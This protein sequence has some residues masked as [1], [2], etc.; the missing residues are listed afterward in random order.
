MSDSLRSLISSKGSEQFTQKFLA[1]KSKFCFNMFYLRFLKKKILK[2]EWITHFCSFPLFCWAMLVNCTFCSI[3]MSNVS[4][5]LIL[6]TKNERMS[7]SLIFLSESLICSFFDKKLAIRSET[8]W[9]KS[10]P[11]FC[12]IDPSYWTGV[13][14][15]ETWQWSSSFAIP[16]EY[17]TGGSS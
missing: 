8:K 12:K 5:S 4:E 3:Q 6:F 16:F 17:L 15:K 13:S 11:A 1:K 14:S 10:Q 2:N 7:E 9:A